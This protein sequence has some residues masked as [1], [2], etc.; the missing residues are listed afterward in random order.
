MADK[1]KHV[2]DRDSNKRVK[3]SLSIGNVTITF[4]K[5]GGEHSINLASLE[6]GQLH[7]LIMRGVQIVLRNAIINQRKKA[8]GKLDGEGTAK[9]V[10]IPDGPANART[11]RELDRVWHAWQNGELGSGKSSR[12]GLDSITRDIFLELLG[13]NGV[14]VNDLKAK[15]IKTRWEATTDEVRK[16]V[17]AEAA[18]ERAAREARKANRPTV[19]F[20]ADGAGEVVAADSE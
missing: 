3:R 7:H 13:D 19:A 8:A 4:A 17:Q 15:D 2:A 20:S 18:K 6:D 11:K 5:D 1:A 16:F 9:V 12:S 14:K 10:A